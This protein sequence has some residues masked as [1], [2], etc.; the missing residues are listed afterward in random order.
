M[1]LR[2]TLQRFSAMKPLALIHSEAGGRRF[3]PLSCWLYLLQSSLSKTSY[4]KAL[5]A[6]AKTIFQTSSLLLERRSR[7]LLV[8]FNYQL[9]IRSQPS[10]SLLYPQTAWTIFFM[11]SS[12]SLSDGLIDSLL[13]DCKKAI[14]KL[15]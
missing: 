1:S 10:S 4:Q 12:F 3:L 6:A 8:H 14:L 11:E 15:P 9:L 7:S 2:G 5:K 13:E